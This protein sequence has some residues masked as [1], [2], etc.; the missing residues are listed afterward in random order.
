MSRFCNLGKPIAAAAVLFAALDASSLTLG[1]M[2]GAA[3]LGR[4]LDV[5]VVVQPGSSG[6]AAVACLDATVSYGDARQPAS[7]ISLGVDPRPDQS[8]LVNVYAHTSVSEPVVTVELHAGCGTKISRQY[9][10]FADPVGTASVPVTPLTQAPIPGARLGFEVT[11][12]TPTVATGKPQ[13]T[14]WPASVASS[15]PP[16]ASKVQTPAVVKAPAPKAERAPAVAAKASVDSVSAVVEDLRR[17]LDALE[18]S[19]NPSSTV[20]EPSGP[21]LQALETNL[22]ALQVATAKNQENVQRLKDSIGTADPPAHTSQLIAL[23]VG[24]LAIAALLALRWRKQRATSPPWW[25]PAEAP[26]EEQVLLHGLADTPVNAPAAESV[27]AAPAQ[28]SSHRDSPTGLEVDIVLGDSDFQGLVVSTPQTTQGPAAA[29]TSDAGLFGERDAPP[30]DARSGQMKEMP[31][32][33]QQAEFFV[34]LGQHEEATK[35]L[36]AGIKESKDPIPVVY[37]DLLSLLHTLSRRE[38]FE[39]YRH[40]FQQQFTGLLPD[41]SNFL[42]EGN[43]LEVYTETCGQIESLWP[44]RDALVYIESCLLRQ[45][46]DQPEQGFDLQAFRD[47]LML[48]GVLRHL[49]SAPDSQPVAIT[50]S[51]RKGSMPKGTELER[52]SQLNLTEPFPPI[53]DTEQVAPSTSDF[54]LTAPPNNLIEFDMGELG[55]A[56]KTSGP[57]S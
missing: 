26:S 38:E 49:G 12:S 39:R 22:K 15:V 9:I 34:A 25:E 44:S 6:D 47:L 57:Q 53:G 45:P 33:R 13:P 51:D 23:A 16:P 3:V 7:T 40:Q 52:D 5:S 37:L 48:H 4:P 18:Q 30:T 50:T 42:A 11:A 31:D 19:S 1:R 17:R 55:N 2:Q 29:A 10:L 24:G 56:K 28:I 32:V 8:L 41:Y 46:D 14:Q 27:P 36:E 43:G 21:A 20:P 35:V 54:E